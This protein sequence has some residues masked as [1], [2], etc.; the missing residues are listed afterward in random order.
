MQA[1]KCRADVRKCDKI[2]DSYEVR[3]PLVGV[4]AINVCFA[5]MII[6]TEMEGILFCL[7]EKNLFLGDK[8]LRGHD[9]SL[10][11]KSARAMRRY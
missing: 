2:S 11:L 8:C 9:V 10:G 7:G 1:T 4:E 6:R 3:R 5:K